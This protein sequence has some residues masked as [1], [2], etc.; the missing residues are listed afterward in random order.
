[1]VYFSVLSVVESRVMM[2]HYKIVRLT[3]CMCIQEPLEARKVETLGPRA[4]GCMLLGYPE[5]VTGYRLW[6]S[7]DKRC[8]NSGDVILGEEETFSNS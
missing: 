8:M 5:G 3:C 1:M 4:I 2:M 6:L 7:A